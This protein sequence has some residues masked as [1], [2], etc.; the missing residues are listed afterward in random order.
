[1]RV[2]FPRT[3]VLV[4]VL[5]AVWIMPDP[6]YAAWY[7]RLMRLV[8]EH[9]RLPVA[10]SDS[11]EQQPGWEIGWGSDIRIDEPPPHARAS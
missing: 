7:A 11:Y 10:Y 4:V 2:R 3:A 1:M 8:A 5:V 9:D 6:A